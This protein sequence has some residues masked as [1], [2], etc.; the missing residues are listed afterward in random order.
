[1]KNR[2][3]SPG[4]GAWRDRVGDRRARQGAGRHVPTNEVHNP[5]VAASCGRTGYRE[6]FPGSS[7]GYIIPI[8]P[9]GPEG[10]GTGKPYL[11]VVDGICK[12]LPPRLK[13]ESG[14]ML[15]I[16][17]DLRAAFTAACPSEREDEWQ[18]QQD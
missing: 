17:T 18:Y 13:N 14:V 4:V 10:P 16:P 2:K 11:G 9:I 15:D 6:R 3:A 5:V 1:L 12:R 7:T 8:G